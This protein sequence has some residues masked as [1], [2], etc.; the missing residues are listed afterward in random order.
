MRNQLKLSLCFLFLLSSAVWAEGGKVV[1]S[2]GYFAIN[3]KTADTSSSISNPS[4]FHLGYLQPKWNNW[5]FKL[6][7]S[8]LLADF[9]GSDMGY[10]VDAGINYYPISDA[11]DEKFTSGP[12]TVYRYQIW[13]PFVGMS[14]NQ[15]SFQSIRNSYAGFGFSGGTERYYNEDINFRAEARYVSL[16]GSGESEATETSVWLGIV[17]KL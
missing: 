11:G 2:Y 13:R 9:S 4:A 15:R 16:A 7:Y 8:V 1:A 6:G 12:V 5:E 3:A 17:F 10:G 14:F